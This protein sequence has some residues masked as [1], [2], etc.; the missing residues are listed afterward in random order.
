MSQV[1]PFRLRLTPR[2]REVF[3]VYLQNLEEGR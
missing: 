2:Q 3:K 1:A